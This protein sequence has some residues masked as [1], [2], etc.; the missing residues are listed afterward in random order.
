MPSHP[1]RLLCTG[2]EAHLLQ[3]RC[4]VLRHAGY[5]ARTATLPEAEILVCTGDYDL[6]IISAGLSEWDRGR[7]LLAAAAKT[8]TYVLNG[9]TLA[10]DLLAQVEQRLSPVNQTAD[11]QR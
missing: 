10:A 5:D 8:P 2:N 3:T 9:L 4:A 1:A 11:H 6:V 7:I